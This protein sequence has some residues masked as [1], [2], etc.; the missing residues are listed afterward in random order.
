MRWIKQHLSLLI[1]LIAL[2]VGIESIILTSRAVSSHEQLVGKNYAIIL[3][4]TAKLDINTI[5]AK[6]PESSSLVELDTTAVLNDINAKF[7]GYF[8][9]ELKKELPYFY[10]LKL[11]ILP[12]QYQIE[13]IEQDLKSINGIVRVESFSKSLNQTYRLLVLLKCCVSVLSILISILSLLLMMKQIEIWRFEHSERM[14]IM[15]YF[16]APSKMKN[17]PLYRL[18]LIDSIIS[19][20]FVIACV[21]LLVKSPKFASITTMLGIDIFNI[22]NLALDFLILLGS[23]YVI[24]MICVFVVILFQKEP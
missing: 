16:G 14:E 15:T 5:K 18:A 24:S 8:V 22:N 13:E 3:V 19:S 17:A 12:N 2:L 10:S 7:N 23:A 4:S 21:A 11:N 1:P 9:D 6:I 20:V